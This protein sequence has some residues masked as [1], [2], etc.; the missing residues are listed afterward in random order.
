M[1]DRDSLFNP[2]RAVQ[3]VGDWFEQRKQFR[4]EALA[5]LRRRESLPTSERVKGDFYQREDGQFYRNPPGRQVW[6]D[7]TLY[8]NGRGGW[9]QWA[10]G[11][12]KQSDLASVSAHWESIDGI[13]EFQVMNVAEDGR[14]LAAELV[15][16]HRDAATYELAECVSHGAASEQ[17]PELS[18]ADCSDDEVDAKLQ[19]YLKRGVNHE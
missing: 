14:P 10:T 19:E 13:G 17:A 7:T 5:S 12:R 2:A 18:L 9:S 16:L 4:A 3:R 6:L 11:S 1:F 15:D 8:P